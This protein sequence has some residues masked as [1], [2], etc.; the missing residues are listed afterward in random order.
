MDFHLSKEQ[1]D[2]RKAAESFAEG[3]F[4]P[5]LISE[6]EREYRFPTAI[7]QKA[8]ELGFIGMHIPEEYGGQGL[9]IQEN[10]LVFE[11]FCRKDPGVGLA[12]A[13]SDL[14]SGIILRYG[15]DKQKK[16]TLSSICSGKTIS[17]LAYLEEGQQDEVGCFETKA[18]ENGD[19]YLIQGNKTFVLNLTLPGP[20]VVMCRL[21]GDSEKGEIAAFLFHK[22]A[23]GLVPEMLGDRV[24][25]R[26]IP[27]GN[28]TFADLRVPHEGLL[29]KRGDGQSQLALSLSEMNIKASAVGTGIAQGAFDMALAYAHRRIQFGRKIVSFEA[30]RG[31]LTDMATRI[32]FSRLLTHKAAW[33]FDRKSGDSKLPEM[34]KAVAAE[35]ALQVAKDALHIFG[36]YGYVVDYRIERFYRDAS[37]VDIIGLPGH[38]NK[39]SLA[40]HVIGRM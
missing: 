27:M 32:E 34:A 6:W 20:A 33:S 8:C 36:G 40:D 38:S 39:K 16:M 37:M 19:G 3:E 13:L 4:N 1:E 31:R 12:L 29:G 18:I 7:W 23:D 17:T 2:I 10:A 15:T 26:M 30:I 14:G 24:G 25:M 35:T 11:A 22:N 9:G 21:S 5:D 28:L